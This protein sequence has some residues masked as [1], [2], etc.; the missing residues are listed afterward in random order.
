MNEDSKHYLKPRCENCGTRID[1]IYHPFKYKFQWDIPSYCP[2]CGEQ[3]SINKK[4]NLIDN[5]E[6]RCLM[7]CIMFVAFLVVI[8]II[9][10]FF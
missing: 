10:N 9:S 6:L 3:I 2:N 1:R 4:Q 8:G 5:E 7:Y